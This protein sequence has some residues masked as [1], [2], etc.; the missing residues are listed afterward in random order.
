MK[1]A[2]LISFVALFGVISAFNLFTDPAQGWTKKNALAAPNDDG[3]NC[4]E[5]WPGLN[6]PC[7]EEYERFQCEPYLSCVLGICRNIS[8]ST[9]CSVRQQCGGIFPDCI[10]GMCDQRRGPG[11]PCTDNHYC[12]SGR[13]FAKHCVAK[14][15]GAPCHGGDC[16]NGE[17]CDPSSRTCMGSIPIGASC[18]DVFADLLQAALN[19]SSF[20]WDLGAVCDES[21]CDSQTCVAIGSEGLGQTCLSDIECKAGLVCSDTQGVC[22]TGN[23]TCDDQN[24]DCAQGFMCN[25][26]TETDGVCQLDSCYPLWM[27]V[28]TFM[29]SNDCGLMGWGLW[30]VPGTCANQAA[31]YVNTALCCELQAHPGFIPPPGVTCSH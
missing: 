22:V 5:T 15:A 19:S 23:N 11:D 7:A 8:Q 20:I 4:T 26:V 16:K 30:N 17:Y 2:A 14:A 3:G 31:P 10:H 1:S 18:M 28:Y 12:Y 13:C 27:K 24:R 9:P 25:C 21:Y 6:E 29:E